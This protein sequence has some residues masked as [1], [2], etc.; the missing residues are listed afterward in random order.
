MSAVKEQS[1][2]PRCPLCGTPA[3]PDPHGTFCCPRCTPEAARK[4]REYWRNEA[5]RCR[6]T[7]E[8]E[9]GARRLILQAMRRN[10]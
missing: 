8:E 9:A 10:D 6:L 4:C 3:I 2:P 7:A 1:W 5:E